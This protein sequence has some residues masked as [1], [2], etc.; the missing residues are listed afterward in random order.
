MPGY[1]I[2]SYSDPHYEAAV[3][4]WES[5]NLA[6]VDREDIAGIYAHGGRLVL[7]RDKKTGQVI[8][9]AMWTF[10]GERAIVRRVAVHV[11]YR[12][13]GV[14]VAMMEEARRQM[15]EAGVKRALL[16][17]EQD[18]AAAC[19]LYTQLGWRVYYSDIQ[20]WIIVP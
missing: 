20:S 13:R 1:R 3:A 4:L 19:S 6:R 9:T 14:A 17:M 18:N 5:T 10:D 16:F 7:A 8:G 2:E 11:D 15:R 12:R